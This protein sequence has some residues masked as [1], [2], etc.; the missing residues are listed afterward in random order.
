[1][2]SIRFFYNLVVA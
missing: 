2:R 1:M